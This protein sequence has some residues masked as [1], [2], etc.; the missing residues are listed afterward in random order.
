MSRAAG[1][2]FAVGMNSECDGGV[3]LHNY[4]AALVLS[5]SLSAMSIS[6]LIFPLPHSTKSRLYSTSPVTTSLPLG[7]ITP[8]TSTTQLRGFAAF[9]SR[10]FV[11]IIA[12]GVLHQGIAWLS[13]APAYWF[14][15]VTGSANAILAGPQ[16]AWVLKQCVYYLVHCNENL[17]DILDRYQYG[18]LFRSLI[19]L[20]LIVRMPTLLIHPNN[21]PRSLPLRNPTHDPCSNGVSIKHLGYRTSHQR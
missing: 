12:F 15:K 2:Q 8:P 1:R 9:R 13:L 19:D 6:S 20:S 3:H 11:H 7:N 17:N 4:D 21:K 16:V 10:P 5:C 18:S 14:F